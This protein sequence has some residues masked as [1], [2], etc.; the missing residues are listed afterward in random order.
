MVNTQGG[1]IH[2]RQGFNIKKVDFVSL[3]VYKNYS[4]RGQLLLTKNSFVEPMI[5]ENVILERRFK[6]FANILLIDTL[7]F[8]VILYLKY[9]RNISLAIQ[10]HYSILL[11][12]KGK[13]VFSFTIYKF[14]SS[15]VIY[16]TCHNTLWSWTLLV[17]LL[18]IQY[19]IIF[20]QIDIFSS[21]VPTQQSFP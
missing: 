5:F 10:I 4:E 12:I 3:P 20:P 18:K 9:A 16:P 2:K 7:L 1:T 11:L 15:P 21:M 8:M 19:S 13:F 17:P 14:F 6:L